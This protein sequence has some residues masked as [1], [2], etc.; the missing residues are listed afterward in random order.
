MLGYYSSGSSTIA[1][2]TCTSRYWMLKADL[3]LVFYG[4]PPLTAPAGYSR[5][6]LA[7]QL[8]KSG[9]IIPPTYVLRSTSDLM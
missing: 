7:S 1:L 2:R 6:L 8:K 5:L 3:V 9:T 4:L